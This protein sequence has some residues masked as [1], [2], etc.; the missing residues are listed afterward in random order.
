MPQATRRELADR[1]AAIG[2]SLEFVGGG[3]EVRLVVP[4][5]SPASEGGAAD[6]GVVAAERS[7]A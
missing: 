2:G 3:G 6:E 5:G 7:E 1:A 4:L